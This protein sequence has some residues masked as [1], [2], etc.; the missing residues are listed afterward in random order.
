[1]NAYAVNQLPRELLF[2]Q[3]LS[4]FGLSDFA[5]LPVAGMDSL[6]I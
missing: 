5:G 4:L 3:K 6:P 1:M 2:H